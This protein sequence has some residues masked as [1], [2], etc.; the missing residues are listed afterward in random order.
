MIGSME[1]LEDVCLARLK[2]CLPTG[3]VATILADRG[4]DEIASEHRSGA[5]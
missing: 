3:D 2:E 1:G 5:Q 4:R